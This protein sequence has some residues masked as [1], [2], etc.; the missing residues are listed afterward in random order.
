LSEDLHLLLYDFFTFFNV[1][2]H[3]TAT[4]FVLYLTKR[5]LNQLEL[6]I[7]VESQLE[8]GKNVSIKKE[9]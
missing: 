7:S 9:Q 5:V 4:G 6:D 1:R 2:E 8:I 3:Q